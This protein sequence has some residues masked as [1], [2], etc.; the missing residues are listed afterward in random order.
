MIL[1]EKDQ[2]VK[3]IKIDFLQD[4]LTD[5]FLLMQISDIVVNYKEA[6]IHTSGENQR[7]NYI[8][9]PRG[10]YDPER[11]VNHHI[12]SR[13]QAEDRTS[14]QGLYCNIMEHS[15]I[16][17]YLAPILSYLQPMQFM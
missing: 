7:V 10:Y 11:V 16:P 4:C 5:S 1:E 17:T 15:Q 8:K 13:S 12:R 9:L 3:K 6:N 14:C 2:E